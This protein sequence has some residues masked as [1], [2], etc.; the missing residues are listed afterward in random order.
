MHV[1]VHFIYFGTLYSASCD[2]SD[3]MSRLK[4]ELIPLSVSLSYSLMHMI[5]RVTKDKAINADI[6]IMTAIIEFAMLFSV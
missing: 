1:A 5:I 3:F 4:T 2:L 6:V